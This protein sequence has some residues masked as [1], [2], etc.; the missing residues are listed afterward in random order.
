MKKSASFESGMEELTQ[1]VDALES[2]TLTL[3]ESFKAYERGI[4]LAG[5]LKKILTE[6]DARITAL[7]ATLVGIEETDISGEVGSA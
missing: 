2:G 4:L 7:Q 6:G 1:L 3:D 5:R